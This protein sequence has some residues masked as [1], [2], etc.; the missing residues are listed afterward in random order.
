M[1][2][3]ERH[4]VPKNK[5]F[6]RLV[7]ERMAKTGESYVTAR[8]RLLESHGAAAAV[9]L[10]LTEAFT[11]EIAPILKLAQEEATL[12]NRPSILATDLLLGLLDRG[13]PAVETL[14]AINVSTAALRARLDR[15]ERSSGTS[16]GFAP[17]CLAVLQVAVEESRERDEP[18]VGGIALLLALASV[19]GQAREALAACGASEERLRA[20]LDDNV[21]PSEEV[22][23][24]RAR[25][26][27]VDV[28]GEEAA[29][30]VIEGLVLSEQHGRVRLDVH[31]RRPDLVIGR[32]GATLD[33]IRSQLVAEFGSL[34][35]NAMEIKTL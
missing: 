8:A 25:Q 15:S 7:R 24:E 1:S 9:P 28:L 31:T 26:L 10:D 20:S 22:V 27:F 29:H 11:W 6:K 13:G 34:F 5:N 19:D 4:Q 35:V 32:R 21:T 18:P 33:S 12:R 30:N 16:T 3:L 17:E 14:L 2:A 23:L